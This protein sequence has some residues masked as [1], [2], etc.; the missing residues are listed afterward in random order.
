MKIVI[1]NKSWIN[2]KKFIPYK[3]CIF[4][5]KQWFLLNLLMR[6]F[7]LKLGTEEIINCNNIIFHLLIFYLF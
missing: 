1:Q 2:E 3:G 7:I 5:F 6:A 4:G